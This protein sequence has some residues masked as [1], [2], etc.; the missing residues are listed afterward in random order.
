MGASY[1]RPSLNLNQQKNNMLTAVH[2]QNLQ[3]LLSRAGYHTTA[4]VYSDAKKY[5]AVEIEIKSIEPKTRAI[6]AKY[7]AVRIRKTTQP[8]R[9]DRCEFAIV[10]GCGTIAICKNKEIKVAI[11]KIN[12]I[13]CARCKFFKD[14]KK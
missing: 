4:Q 13:I 12:T 9:I 3:H 8:R 7:D 1:R 5:G 11:D 10:S 6:Y 14:G 2:V